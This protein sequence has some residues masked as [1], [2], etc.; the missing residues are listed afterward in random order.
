M[1]A[2]ERPIL[3][4]SRWSALWPG[5]CAHCDARSSQPLCG[6]CLQQDLPLRPRCQRCG[7]AVAQDGQICGHCLLH[8]PQWA[9]A[10]AL[11]DY[12]FPNDQFILRMKFGAEPAL[13]RWF[14]D[15]L[16]SRWTAARLP[17]PDVILP[18]PLS[19]ERLRERGFNPA[20][21]MARR[22]ATNLD[23]PADPHSLLRVRHGIAQ[24]QLPLDARRRN[25]RGAYVCQTRWDGKSLLLVDD[26]MTSGATLAESAR[27]LLQQGATA[28]WVAV[29]LRTPLDPAP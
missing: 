14:G 17:Q 6:A 26:V 25:I 29:A 5:R 19:R 10:L 16:G 13:G 18:V 22:I 23:R 20:W 24:S 2:L 27:V 9:G 3:P 4:A 7:V 28:V 1:S 11:G 15:L 12:H 21:E 8:P